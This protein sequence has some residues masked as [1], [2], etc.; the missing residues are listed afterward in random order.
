MTGGRHVPAPR[1]PAAG[2][3]DA[4]GPGSSEPAPP[5]Q[6]AARPRR[7]RAAR[8]CPR[9]RRKLA[10]SR[11]AAPDAAFRADGRAPRPTPGPRGA[12]GAAPPPRAFRGRGGLRGRRPLGGRRRSP[13]PAPPAGARH[14]ATDLRPQP[15][16]SAVPGADGGRPRRV[17]E[18]RGGGPALPPATSR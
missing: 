8:P 14:A 5:A 6:R 3:A 9:A 4:D 17:A 1:A 15:S 16:S 11:L 7:P 10:R 13:A 18:G 12:A 2:P